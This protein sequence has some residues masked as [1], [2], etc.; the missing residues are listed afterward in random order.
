MPKI[1]LGDEVTTTKKFAG[2]EGQK[3]MIVIIRGSIYGIQFYESEKVKKG[4][5]KY[6]KN[7]KEVDQY[8]LHTLDSSLTENNGCYVEKDE[9]IIKS[10]E[11][12]NVNKTKFIN[13]LK[14]EL[15]RQRI[16][17][18]DDIKHIQMRIKDNINHIKY[19]TKEIEDL[20]VT[21]K[22]NKNTIKTLTELMK[23]NES[24]TDEFERQY[25]KLLKNKN[26]KNILLTDEDIIIQT[27]DLLY[28]D[29]Y[30]K[31]IPLGAYYIFVNK[32]FQSYQVVNYRKHVRRNAFHPC[33]KMSEGICL[34]D[35][36]TQEISK[37]LE[38]KNLKGLVFC[39]IQFIKEPNYRAPHIS[40]Q[41]FIHAQDVTIKPKNI[42]DWK[43]RDYWN[44]NEEW[45]NE[46]YNE[47]RDSAS[48]DLAQ[49]EDYEDDS[50]YVDS[51]DA[52]I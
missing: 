29:K 23:D 34:G 36:M 51:V 47:D 1:Y 26:I 48:T 8:Q 18:P 30:N 52:D 17:A 37:F 33:I 19:K 43:N 31:N 50:D 20:G 24:Y 5:S 15:V 39:L 7:K 11:N 14:Q 40:I 32:E 25:D 49:E 22:L 35:G 21:I 12:K 3:G 10:Y 9:I 44:Q 2:G 46:K 38:E 41:N 27:N 6:N 16:N 42:S 13:H 4:F 45:D 28:N